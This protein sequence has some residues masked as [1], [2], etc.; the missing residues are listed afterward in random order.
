MTPNNSPMSDPQNRRNL[1]LAVILST[2]FMVAWQIFVLQPEQ[3]AAEAARA[4]QE[5]MSREDKMRAIVDGVEQTQT[6][7]AFE[8]LDGSP[9]IAAIQPSAQERAAQNAQRIKINTSR[10]HGSLSLAGARIDDVTLADY[11]VSLDEG[12][13]EIKALSRTDSEMPYFAEF[14][15]VDANQQGVKLPS[16]TT[17]WKVMGGAKDVVLTPTSPV[18]LLWD[19]GQGVRFVRTISVDEN[20][21]FSVEQRVENNSGVALSLSPYALINRQFIDP[22]QEYF[23]LHEGPLAVQNE[24]LEEVSYEDLRDDGAQEFKTGRGWLGFTDKYW[25]TA[26]VPDDASEHTLRM[27]YY[28]KNNADRYQADMLGQPKALAVGGEITTKTHLFAGAKEVHLLDSYSE[29]FE[30][31]LFDRAVDFGMLYFLTRP[32]FSAL[33]FFYG[34]VGNFGVAIMCLTVCVK[35]VLFP[36]ANKSYKAM[37]QMKVLMPQIQELREKH[38]DDK[39]AMN[40]EMMKLYQKEK[41]N[42]MSGCLPILVQI[43]IFFALY[44]VLFVS[45]EMRH[46]PFF[47]WIH[48]LSAPDPTTIF[49]LFGLIPVDLPSFLQIGIWPVIMCITMILQQKL[50]PKPTD[51]MQAK[52]MAMLPY[53]F[54]FLFATFPAGLVIYWAWNNTLSI[55]QQWII[56]RR[57]GRN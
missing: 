15:W 26:L 14:G 21:M 18:T 33:T 27:N 13:A 24:I 3:E 46:A 32:F 51:E 55:T 10:M 35:L 40:Q 12:S 42:P 45:I 2:V 47:G 57:H 29:K 44:K 16:K 19:N 11:K 31:P 39:M 52:V 1:L 43:P 20:F 49:N 23:I 17:M 56:M 54:L 7:R 41:V 8:P 53:F 4:T 6:L 22:G 36:L 25:L 34:L 5:A 38:K 48:D 28:S 50:N 9:A 37:G 30:I